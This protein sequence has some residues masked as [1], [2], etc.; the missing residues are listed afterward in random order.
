MEA[1][2]S[3]NPDKFSDPKRTLKGEVRAYVEY[4]GLDSLWFNTGTLCNLTCDNCYIESS[5]TNDALVFL[6]LDEVRAFL[7]E[8][9]RIGDRPSEIGFTGGEPFVNPHMCDMLLHVLERGYRALVLTNAMRPMQRP[10]VSE[11]LAALQARF[12]DQ[13]SMR[14]SLDH[15]TSILHEKERGIGTWAPAV[16]GLNWLSDNAF[17][18]S[19]AGRTCWGESVSDARLGYADLFRTKG[20]GI[21][22]QA[23]AE[24]VLF[25]EMQMETDLPE[26]TVDCWGIL[27]KSPSQMMC[28]NSRMVVKRKEAEEP[29]VVACTLLPYTEEFDYGA[30]LIAASQPTY[31]NHPHC[32]RF[33]VLGGASCSG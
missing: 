25:P 7:D 31:L 32:A 9:E 27:G 6:T 15:Y 21:N 11:A 23:P 2:T 20:W 28:A 22:A 30:S 24:L 16:K 19:V 13:L 3:L 12:G 33:C 26:I 1:F 17:N 4:E 18:I 8:G 29:S 10:R 14:V 5:P